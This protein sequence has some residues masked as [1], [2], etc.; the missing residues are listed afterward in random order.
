MRNLLIV[1][2]IACMLIGLSSCL[3]NKNT[4]EADQVEQEKPSTQTE[5]SQKKTFTGLRLIIFGGIAGLGVST[6]LCFFWKPIGIAG[7][8]ACGVMIFSAVTLNQHLVLIS[9]ICLIAVLAA[10]GLLI[11]Y[12]Y[13]NRKE[14][15]KK[16]NALVEVVTL[17]EAAKPL[18]S[19][20]ATEAIYGN[21]DHNGMAGKIESNETEALVTEIRAEIPKEGD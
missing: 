17:N 15:I 16:A 4:G 14:L 7:L 19:K 3:H 13:K 1:I 8:A 12:A 18:L 10:I 6:A 20:T 21:K 2:V 11:W 9:W 5:V